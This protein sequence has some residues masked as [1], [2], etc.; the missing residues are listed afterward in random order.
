MGVEKF[1]Y[2]LR[3]RKFELLT[4]HKALEDIRKKPYFNNNRVNR[5]IE[6]IQDDDF[7]VQYI[8][9]E[10]MGDADALSRQYQDENCEGLKE[11]EKSK[12]LQGKIKKHVIVKNG[13]EYWEFDDGT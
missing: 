7:S 5:W 12:Q 4:D 10:F 6:R 13:K 2:E 11:P 1:E 9:G 3:G 8:K